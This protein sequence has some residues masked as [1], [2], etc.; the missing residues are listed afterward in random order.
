MLVLTA[1]AGNL[2]FLRVPETTFP[3]VLSPV[4]TDVFNLTGVLRL[5]P[6]MHFRPMNFSVPQISYY[7]LHQ[8]FL[9]ERAVY[10]IVWDATRFKGLSGID[11]DQ[12]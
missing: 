9:T 1:W 5:R 10:V 4:A 6:D 3:R 12:V 8:Y 11:L 2:L 7:G